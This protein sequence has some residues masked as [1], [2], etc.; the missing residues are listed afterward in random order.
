MSSR[1]QCS[2]ANTKEQ[3]EKRIQRRIDSIQPAQVVALRKVYASLRDGMSSP[4]EWFEVDVP[5]DA[6]P[7]AASAADALRAAA[8]AKTGKLTTPPPVV[9]DGDQQGNT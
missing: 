7:A 1:P 8:A 3:I 9:D 2:N 6:K 5:A 4:S